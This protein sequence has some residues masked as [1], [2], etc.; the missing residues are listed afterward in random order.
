MARMGRLESQLADVASGAT[1]LLV[2]TQMLAKGHHLPHVTLVVVVNADGGLYASDFRALEHT[3]QLLIQVAGRAGRA[4]H[5]G[6]GLV[7]TLHGDDPHLV[8]LAERGYEALANQLLDERRIAHLPP[9][10]F[11]ALLRLESPRAET[12]EELGSLAANFLCPLIREQGL[13]VDCL[14]PVP[15]PME[16]RQNRYHMQLML[17]ADRRSQLHEAVS[18]LIAWLEAAPEARRVR[19]SV[20]IDPQTLA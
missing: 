11:L 18:Q 19:W 4:N 9:F 13:A 6:R 3:A 20:D 15:A 7:Q 2:G 5:P 12:A 10:R 14:G 8:I 16:R 17:A 1:Q